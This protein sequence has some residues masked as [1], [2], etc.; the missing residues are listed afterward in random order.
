V[1]LTYSTKLINTALGR[2]GSLGLTTLCTSVKSSDEWKRNNSRRAARHTREQ[3]Q[4]YGS[5]LKKVGRWG[6]NGVGAVLVARG[7]S[8]R[9]DSGHQGRNSIYLVSSPSLN[10]LSQ[11]VIFIYITNT[12][13]TL[14]YPAS[15]G[16]GV[17]V[18]S[19]PTLNPPV[20]Q[21]A[22]TKSHAARPRNHCHQHPHCCSYER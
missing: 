19:Q 1:T 12:T 21:Q 14:Y 11:L 20:P 17:L 7:A 6:G 4:G 10:F 15:D 13:K 16:S 5:G 2:A 8:V 18:A 9:L 22:E 3:R